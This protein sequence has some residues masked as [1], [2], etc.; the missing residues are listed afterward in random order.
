MGIFW[1]GLL[2]CDLVLFIKRKIVKYIR[3]LGPDDLDYNGSDFR[4]QISWMAESEL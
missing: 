3:T 2:I 1:D 4:V